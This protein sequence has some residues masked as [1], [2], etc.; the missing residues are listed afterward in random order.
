MVLE[1]GHIRTIE[2]NDEHTL[3]RTRYYTGCLKK[4]IFFLP[5]TGQVTVAV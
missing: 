3:L 1:I 5:A 2:N 4:T